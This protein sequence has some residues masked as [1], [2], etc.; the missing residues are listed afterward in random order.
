VFSAVGVLVASRHPGNATGWL[1]LGV[2]VATGLGTLAGSYADAWVAGGSD[3]PRWLGELAAWYGTLSWIPF[4]LVPCTFVLLLFPDGHLL[5]P[6]WRWVAWCAGAGSRASSSP[7]RIDPGPLEDQP[8]IDNPFGVDTRVL[9][10]AH[11]ALRAP[12]RD[13]HG[14]LGRLGGRPLPP[15]ARRAASADEVARAGRD[16]RGGHGPRLRGGF[17]HLV[18]RRRGQHRVHGRRAAAADRRPASRSC[19]TASTTSTSSS[20]ARW[21]TAR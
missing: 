12:A 6:R 2:G 13:R 14:R 1:F 4:I 3:G 17:G 18:E 5:S 8:T 9:G 7:P 21:S 20:T 10:P 16:G 15:R 11:G 19:A